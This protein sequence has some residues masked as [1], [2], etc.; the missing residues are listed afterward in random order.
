MKKL[1][2]LLLLLIFSFSAGLLWKKA[3]TKEPETFELANLDN[4]FRPAAFPL[5]ARPFVLFLDVRERGAVF[6]KTLRSIFSQVYDN[7]RLICVDNASGEE[8]LSAL[9]D[10]MQVIRNEQP[11]SFAESIKQAISSCADEEI[12]VVLKEG[13]LLAHEWVLSRLNQYYSDPDL[14]LTF[15]LFREVPSYRLGA[16][17]FEFSELPL[18][19]FLVRFFRVVSEPEFLKIDQGISSN[20]QFIPEI[21]MLSE[22]NDHS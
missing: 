8:H 15:S 1:S 19:T 5:T 11:L 13:D 10:Q 16:I 22:R 21:L 2:A 6:E 17:K 9:N 14:W 18:K 4:G 3:Q 20:F 7:F 12:F